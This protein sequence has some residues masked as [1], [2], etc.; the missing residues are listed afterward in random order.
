[1]LRVG[2]CCGCSVLSLILFLG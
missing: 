1:L 2:Y